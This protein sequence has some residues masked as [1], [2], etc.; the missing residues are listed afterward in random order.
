MNPPVTIRN[1]SREFRLLI[2]AFVITLNFGYFTGLI[3]IEET[4][5]FQPKG[6]ETNYLGNEADEDAEV[7]QFKKSEKEILTVVHNHVLS[8]SL[9]F[10]LLGAIVLLTSVNRRLKVALMIEPFVSIVLTFGGIY[11]LWMGI[12]WFK[13]VIALSGFALTLTMITSSF[14][15]L[16]ACFSAR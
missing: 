14:L 6:V 8:F 3:F 9:I 10:F 11:L 7:M 5:S 1:F 15:I 16:K 2:A 4:T 13:Y 12:T